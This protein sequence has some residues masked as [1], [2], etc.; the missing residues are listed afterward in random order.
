MNLPAC[1]R[2]EADDFRSR[3]SLLKDGWEEVEIL[4]T[5]QRTIGG[6]DYE[7]ARVV[8]WSGGDINRLAQIAIG[9]VQRH[10]MAVVDPVYD[11]WDHYTRGLI[12]ARKTHAPVFVIGEPLMMG[13][14]ILRD[15]KIDL[16]RVTGNAIRDGRGTELVNR[17]MIYFRDRGIRTIRAGT[18]MTNEPAQ[19][20]YSKLGFTV[21][22]RERTFHKDLD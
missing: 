14:I 6:E 7:C 20:F 10:R 13:F 17:A 9:G 15:G 18:Q 5:W 11:N 19:R 8:A 22:K 21:V 4:E 12:E 3:E 2:I 16:I 1:V